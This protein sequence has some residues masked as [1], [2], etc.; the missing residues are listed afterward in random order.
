TLRFLRLRCGDFGKAHL[1]VGEPGGALV[2][3]PEAANAGGVIRKL[4][5]RIA[6]SARVQCGHPQKDTADESEFHQIRAEFLGAIH[7]KEM[8]RFDCNGK[9]RRLSP[10][11]FARND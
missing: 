8:L 10:L 6:G 11:W 4:L 7:P 3:P 5:D 1:L 9:R 2:Y